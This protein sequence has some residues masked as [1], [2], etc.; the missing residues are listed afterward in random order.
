LDDGDWE[1][2][3]GYLLD[4]AEQAWKKDFPRSAVATRLA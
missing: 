1:L 2:V 4:A 3:V